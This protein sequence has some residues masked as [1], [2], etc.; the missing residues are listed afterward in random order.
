MTTGGTRNR[1]WA[2]DEN[3]WAPAGSSPTAS[4]NPRNTRLVARVSPRDRR[5][6]KSNASF[7]PIFSI[8]LGPLE[9]KTWFLL[10]IRRGMRVKKLPFR[11]N[12]RRSTLASSGS[13]ESVVSVAPA[14]PSRSIRHFHRLRNLR[15]YNGRDFE[16]EKTMRTV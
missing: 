1:R 11:R 3:R 2:I 9:S 5:G 8:L 13:S 7:L 12:V 6:R 4:T 10:Q 16:L 14:R 15:S